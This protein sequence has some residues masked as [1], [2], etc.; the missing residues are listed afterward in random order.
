MNVQAINNT[1]F[2]G[3]FNDK[4]KENHGEWKMEYTPY[5][6]ELKT[7]NEFGMAPQTDLDIMTNSLPDNEKTYTTNHK[8]LEY[9]YYGRPKQESGREQCKD[10][11]GTEFYYKNFDTKKMRSKID[12]LPA[13]NRE[14]SLKVL[15]KKLTAFWYMKKQELENI[16]NNVKTEKDS[17]DNASKR[18]DHH[19]NDYDLGI[20]D[21]YEYTEKENKKYMKNE[22]DNIKKS[23][24]KIYNDF[25]RYITLRNSADTVRSTIA[26]NDKEIKILKSARESGN[27]I[28]ISRR[29]LI[30]DPNKAL[31]DA[32]HDLQGSYNKLIA[33]PHKTISVKELLK[34]IGAKINSSGIPDKAVQYVDKIIAGMMK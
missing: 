6:W 32:M 11:F 15:N 1:N 24:D 22:K 19:S 30:N 21:G 5:S 34:E 2:K 17:L 16:K 23:S 20:L 18:F 12:E 3:I 29:F 28:D 10:I 4:S 7:P 26:D 25:E 14:D 31:W 13:M 8:F 9:D 33:L 27:L